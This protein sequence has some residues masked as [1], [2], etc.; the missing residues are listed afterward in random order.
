M[1]RTIHGQ[2]KKDMIGRAVEFTGDAV[3]YGSFMRRII[4]EWPLAC[5]HN[6]T[7]R[8]MN[9]LA[10]IGHAASC[11][12]IQCPESITREA[13]GMLT[14]RQRVEADNQA[15][16]A[17]QCWIKTHEGKDSRLDQAMGIERLF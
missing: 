11:L 4:V 17:L 10:W 9:R 3:L 8:S 16:A 2:E 7:E 5:E 14:D 15:D 13:W 6:L 12:A 1:W